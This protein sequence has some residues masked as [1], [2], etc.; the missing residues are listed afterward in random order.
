MQIEFTGDGVKSLFHGLGL[1]MSRKAISSA[2]AWT[3]YEELIRRAELTWEAP[4]GGL[5]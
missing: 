4:K 2:L 5:L 3:L 1:R